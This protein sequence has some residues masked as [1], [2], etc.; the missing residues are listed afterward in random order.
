MMIEDISRYPITLGLEITNRCN[1]HCPHCYNP[2]SRNDDELTTMEYVAL[3]DAAAELGTQMI[4]WTGG[5]PL[6]RE[7]LE[8][9]VCHALKAHDIKSGITTNGVLL[10]EDRATKLKLAGTHAVQISLDGTTPGRSWQI[11]RT[12]EDE[13]EKIINALRACREVGLKT[14]IAMLLGRE[15]L[16][17]G[18]EM[19]KLA[20]REKVAGVRFCGFTP[21]GRGENKTIRSRFSFE[22]D[23]RS[24]HDFITEAVGKNSVPVMF[25]PG[26][27]PVPPDYCF[28]ECI[29]GMET[30]YIK[31]SGDV[32]PCTAMLFDRFKVGNVRQRSLADI[33]ADP[34]MTEM[35]RYDRSRI[36]GLCSACD[37]TDNCH[38]ACRS[39]T[40]AHT[41]DFDDSFP[42]CLYQ[43]DTRTADLHRESS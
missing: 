33:W 23:L 25:D 20:K 40:Y 7:D 26:F 10:D 5:E 3:I 21:A 13:F 35:A 9:L 16:D 6:L 36:N 37:N 42:L 43:L 39:L 28:H 4:G 30:C 1:L 31:A 17:D 32:Y 38:G 8:E 14:N 15:N 18:R 41:G 12:T 29:A 34:G 27:G 19:L 11:R 2:E 24:L 22:H